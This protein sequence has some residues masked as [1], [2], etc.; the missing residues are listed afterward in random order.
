VKIK[1]WVMTLALLTVCLAGFSYL[2]ADDEGFIGVDNANEE[3]TVDLGNRFSL[4]IW[5]GYSQINMKD[6][7]TYIDYENVKFYSDAGSDYK[8]DKPKNAI[9]AGLDLNYK[10]TPNLKIGP[11]VS[12]I[13]ASAKNVVSLAPDNFQK[14]EETDKYDMT[15]LP[16]LIGGEYFIKYSDRM[17]YNCKL[18]LG[19]GLASMKITYDSSYESSLDP[20]T[21]YTDSTESNWKG[22]NFVGEASIGGD[23]AISSGV[24]LGLDLGYRYAK[25]KKLKSDADSD[26]GGIVFEDEFGKA[27]PLDFSGPTAAI[28]VNFM[29]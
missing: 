15:L 3:Q 2:Y 25:I 14:Y 18:Y 5:G 21:N 12:Y 9:E 26:L 17:S 13:T 4:G 27:I 28:R 19:Y 10:I 22:S 11:R 24:S 16:I 1:S 6:L 29:F 20:D 7:N 23:V 8:Y